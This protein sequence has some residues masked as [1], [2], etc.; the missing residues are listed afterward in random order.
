MNSTVLYTSCL[1]LILSCRNEG[2]KVINTDPVDT[3]T[4]RIDADGDGYF[5]DEDCDDADAASNP[6]AVEVRWAGQQL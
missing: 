6:G 5:N 4:D 2:E 3:A 1:A